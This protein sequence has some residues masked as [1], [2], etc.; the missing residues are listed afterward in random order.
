MLQVRFVESLGYPSARTRL[1]LPASETVTN[2]TSLKQETKA[3]DNSSVLT[4]I[5]PAS[6]PLRMLRLLNVK[7]GKPSK[8]I[9][10]LQPLE[11]SLEN[12]E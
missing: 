3:P 9:I 4:S 2:Y 10:T 8:D 11:F 7:T 6:I 1:L 5:I 12:S